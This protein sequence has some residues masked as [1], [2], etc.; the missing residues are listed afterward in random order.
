MPP[1]P[2]SY[3]LFYSGRVARLVICN[4]PSW[5][6]SVWSMVARVLPESVRKKITIM[7]GTAGLDE[8]IHPTQ[9]PVEYG[10]TDVPLGQAP[11]QLAFL[12]LPQSW[13][14]RDRERDSDRDRDDRGG[15]N[16]S[17]SSSYNSSSRSS[18]S[19]SVHGRSE[20]SDSGKDRDRDRDRE[21]DRSG[22]SSQRK[23]SSKKKKSGS[24][25]TGQVTYDSRVL[26]IFLFVLYCFRWVYLLCTYMTMA[27][28]D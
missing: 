17:Q 26:F 5:F 12:Q 16:D 28:I 2:L 20:A 10:G 13:I 11:Q 3:L 18:M 7:S 1:F 8:F 9:R 15:D 27:Y 6:Y 22:S 4:A 24:S 19:G 25:S 23:K 21:R 14:T